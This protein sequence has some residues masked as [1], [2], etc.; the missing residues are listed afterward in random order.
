MCGITACLGIDSFN[1]CLKSLIQLQNRGYDSAGICSILNNKFLNNKYASTEEYSS[2]NKLE[3]FKEIHKKCEVSIGHTRWATHGSKTDANSHPHICYQGLFS[4]IHNGIIENFKKLKDFL[5]EKNITFK[6]ETDT[7]VICNLLSYFYSL[8]K[9]VLESIN[10]LLN[11]LQG[12]WGICILF[13]EEP[14]RIYATCNGSP[15]LISN[16]EKKAYI[17]SEQSGFCGL[18]NNYFVMK[19]HDLCILEKLPNQNIKI[20]T[21]Q[22]YQLKNLKDN[23][24]GLTPHPFPHWTIKEINEQKESC[25][26][27]MNFGGRLLSKS[28][29]RLGGLENFKE[30]LLLVENIIILGCGSSYNAG[31]VGINYLKE[32]CNFNIVQIYDGAEFNILD[33]PK[34]GKSALILISQSGETKDLHRCIKIAKEN[35]VVTI[36]VINVVDSL[37]ARDVDCGCYVNSGREVA[38]ATTKAFTSQVIILNMIS[39]WFAQEKKINYNLRVKY[40]QDLHNLSNDIENSLDIS[41]KLIPSYLHLFKNFSSCFLLGKKNGEAISREGAL[42]IKEISYIHAESYNSSSLKHGP[43]ALLTPNFPVILISPLDENYSK[44]DNCYHELIS[45]NSNILFIT[46]N[47]EEE[48]ENKII[49][50]VNNTFKDLLSIIP[51]QILAYNLSV[52]KNINPDMPRNL[53]KVVTVE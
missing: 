43:F 8:N 24:Y 46:D 1:F 39:I 28:E 13:K 4:I 29:V 2:L 32:I 36:G 31:L 23:S 12:T 7:E 22:T 37:I 42:K 50:P 34:K 53:A 19:N 38:V 3:E 41:H 52:L 5:I 44:N 21:N 47:L 30:T 10:L 40:I 16:N 14:F 17:S 26:R 48:K 18:V 51:I 45:R 25:Q 9:N 15:L 35:D 6:S 33:I 49:L 20:R 11:K 27:A